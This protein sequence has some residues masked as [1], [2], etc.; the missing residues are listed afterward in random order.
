MPSSAPYYASIRALARQKRAELGVQT[1]TFGI[2]D[3]R[4]IYRRENITID[5][6][7]LPAY[8][9]AIYLAEDGEVSVAIR[10]DLPNEPKLFA[11]AHELKH[12]W[13]DQ[14]LIRAGLLRCGDYNANE[15]EEKGAEVFAAE[16][17]YPEDEFL[18][19]VEACNKSEWQPQDIVRFKRFHSR[20][21]VSYTFIRKGLERR[22]IIAPD[23]FSAIKFQKLEEQIYG[24]PFY[25]QPWFKQRRA[26]SRE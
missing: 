8:L 15:L 2:R 22:G 6:R 13:A 16:F 25:K 12:H 1:I 11:L 4:N 7:K 5:I 9:K 3:I 18:E 20:A 19:D 23:Q 24:L 26:R 17:I 14:A 21:K 10:K